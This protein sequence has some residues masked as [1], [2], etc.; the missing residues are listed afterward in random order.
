MQPPVDGNK[1]NF[2]HTL[3]LEV[4]SSAVLTGKTARPAQKQGQLVSWRPNRPQK[5]H[6]NVDNTSSK[7]GPG[8]KVNYEFLSNGKDLRLGSN[9]GIP[10]LT[11]Q[12]SR[13]KF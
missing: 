10:R 11:L 8:A 3:L 12:H 6:N 9:S 4:H 13:S 2:G 7:R 1:L 5:G